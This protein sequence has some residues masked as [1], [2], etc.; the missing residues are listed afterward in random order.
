MIKGITYN[1]EDQ[2]CKT[3]KIVLTADNISLSNRLNIVKEIYLRD[4]FQLIAPQ[5]Y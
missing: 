1:K 2:V 5:S 4:D 3:N